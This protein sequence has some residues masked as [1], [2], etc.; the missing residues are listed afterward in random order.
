MICDDGFLPLVGPRFFET[1]IKASNLFLKECTCLYTSSKNPMRDQQ[2]PQRLSSDRVGKDAFKRF[3]RLTSPWLQ[4]FFFFMMKAWFVP[5]HFSMI[6][7]S[8]D[9][10]W[11]LF[12]LQGARTIRSSE[13]QIGS[14][15]HTQIKQG[16]SGDRCIGMRMRTRCPNSGKRGKKDSCLRVL[17]H[18]LT[19]NQGSQGTN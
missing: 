15:T 18:G 13:F 16:K 8:S 11:M 17:L 10:P 4:I 14:I 19:S 5:K 6:Q 12:S 7:R 1:L 9:S 3:D 2:T